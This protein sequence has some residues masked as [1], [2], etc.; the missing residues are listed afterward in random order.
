MKYISIGDSGFIGPH[1]KKCLGDKIILNL[2][3][4]ECINNSEHSYCNILEQI[5]LNKKIKENEEILR[6]KKLYII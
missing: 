5:S 3:I 2:D 1:F 6:Y 4:N